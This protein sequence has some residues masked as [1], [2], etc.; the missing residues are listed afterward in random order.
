MIVVCTESSNRTFGTDLGVISIPA[1]WE[2]S[3]RGDAEDAV[4]TWMTR[5]VYV[6]RVIGSRAVRRWARP[7]VSIRSQVKMPRE[8]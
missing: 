1:T 7:K 4:E 8:V 2:N 3:E 5:Q 6:A